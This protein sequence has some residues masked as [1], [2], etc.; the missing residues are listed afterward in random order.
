MADATGQLPT[1]HE[2]VLPEWA[3]YNNHMNVAYYVVAFDAATDAYKAHVGID[4]AYR[5]RTGHSTFAAELHVVYLQEL[6]VGEE[7]DL[8]TYLLDWDAKRHHFIHS[9]WRKRD[10][11]LCATMEVM[12]LHID[13]AARKTAPWPEDIRFNLAALRE[14]HSELS[15]PVQAGRIAGLRN[16]RRKRVI[17]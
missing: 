1:G 6:H 4:K 7:V 16:G 8:T 14:R 15:V 11:A 13:L 2:T 17:P 3:D 9:M 10:G 5:E 12:S